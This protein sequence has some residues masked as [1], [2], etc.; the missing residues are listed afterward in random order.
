[1]WRNRQ[2]KVAKSSLGFL[3][4]L[5][6]AVSLYF[7]SLCDKPV[8]PKDALPICLYSNQAGDSLR[9]T[10]R[11]AINTAQ[12]SVTCIMYSLT[13]EEIL[14]ALKTKNEQGVKVPVACDA[15]ASLG[16]GDKLGPKVTCIPVRKRGLMHNKLVAIDEQ[17]AYLGSSNFTRDSLSLHA[18]LVLGIHSPEV[19]KLIEEKAKN[20]VT[21]KPKKLAPLRLQTKEASK[22]FFE[23][24]FLPD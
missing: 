17:S 14:H 19:A 12:K 24:Y 22:E 23:L 11:D 1:M 7:F 3:I 16:A 13:D 18:N 20:V 4:L 2:Q 10:I 6:Y 5:L 21:T 9:T 15:V 8:L